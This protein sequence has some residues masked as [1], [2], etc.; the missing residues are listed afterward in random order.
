MVKNESDI[1]ES[2][3]RYNLN[4]LDG[5]IILDNQSSD[6][7]LK[8]LNLL[9]NEG[10]NLHIILDDNNEFNQASKLNKLLSHALNEFNAD[11][12]VPLDAD[13][14]IVSNKSGNPRKYIEM[15]ESPAFNLVKWKTYVPTFDNDHEK[16]IPSKITF[17]RDNLGEYSKV[18]LPKELVEKF[19][20]KLTKGSHKLSFDPKYE[21]S[22]NQ[23][24][25]ENLRI[26][27]FPIRSREQIISKI[28]IGW[29]NNLV[30]INR[31]KHESWHFKN[32]FDDLKNGLEIKEKD[33]INFAKKY[34][35]DETEKE[36]NITYDP[37][38]LTFCKNISI[39]YTDNNSNYMT[40]FLE[41]TEKLGQNY[42]NLKKDE[43]RNKEE[44]LKLSDDINNLDFKINNL[45]QETERLNR[46]IKEYE[47]S[48][49]WRI[50][51][52]MRKF[53]SFIKKS[54]N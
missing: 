36:V 2:F 21:Q 28:S 27:H 13:E 45:T 5:M 50:T 33:M 9:K 49:S 18:I 26:A 24:F 53:I 12:I 20:V 14:F 48:T 47:S 52:P 22:I 4:I 54:E 35:M 46:K 41:F 11:I 6:N 16:F 7:T 32:M 29:I 30:D 31:T 23:V 43:K 17:T 3:V 40:N 51:A 19:D 39:K 1:I 25:D 34:S 37:V 10:L 15:I 38:D 8:I 44:I 42:L